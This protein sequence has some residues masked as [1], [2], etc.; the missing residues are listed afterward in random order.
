MKA[1]ALNCYAKGK[2]C[3]GYKTDARSFIDG[4]DNVML[5]GAPEAVLKNENELRE[6]MLKLKTE[7]N[8]RK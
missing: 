4:F 7:R 5:C 1:L 2:R 8:A 3:I 6:Y